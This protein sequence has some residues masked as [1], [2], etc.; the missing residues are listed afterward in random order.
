MSVS[1][2]T[3]MRLTVGDGRSRSH[4]HPARGV[5]GAEPVGWAD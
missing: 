4:R 5:A 3:V 2:G 1:L